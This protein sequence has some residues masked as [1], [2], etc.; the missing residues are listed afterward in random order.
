MNVGLDIGYSAVKATTDGRKI[1]FPSVTGTPEDSPMDLRENDRAISFVHPSNTLVGEEAIMHSRFIQRREDRSWIESDEYYM[2]F[3]AALTE[4]E[5]GSWTSVRIVTGLPVAFYSDRDKLRDRLMGE[6]KAQRKGKPA[7]TFVVSECR[8]IPQPFGTLLAAALDD[9][10]IVGGTDFAKS[11]VG[12][13]DIGGKSTNIF[14]VD[15][16]AEVSRKTASVNLGGWDIIRVIKTQILERFP[17]LDLRDHQ[18]VDAVTHRKLKYFGETIS[19][20]TAIDEV[21]APMADQV[22]AQVTQLW[23]RGAHLDAILMTGGGALLLGDRLKQVFRNAKVVPDPVFANSLG[24]W[25]LSQR[26]GSPT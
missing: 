10:A 13:I 3:L 11:M 23:D 17:E 24:F 5:T 26:S 25:K 14:T 20:G 16:L 22:I 9:F 4:L 21:V 8:V 15:R 6:H 7:Q 12:I 2:L 19:L 1:S 18:V